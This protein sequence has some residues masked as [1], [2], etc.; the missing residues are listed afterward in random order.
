MKKYLI[1]NTNIKKIRKSLRLRQTDAESKLW[2]Y[3]RRRQLKNYKFYRQYSINRY[4]LDFYCPK[5]KLAIEV[6]GDTH[7]MNDGVIEYDKKRQSYIETF[8]VKFLRFT[9]DDIYTNIDEVIEEI[10]RHL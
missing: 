5:L 10:I 1:N 6:D 4:V 9:N 3:L 8:G 2:Y 7:Y